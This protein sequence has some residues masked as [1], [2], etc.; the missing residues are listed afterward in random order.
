MPL[1]AHEN[2]IEQRYFLNHK[3]ENVERSTIADNKDSVWT[4][5]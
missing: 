3:N 4:Y 2:F 5:C 1:I